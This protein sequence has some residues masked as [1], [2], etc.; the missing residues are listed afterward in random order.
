MTTEAQKLYL[1]RDVRRCGFPASDIVMHCT[2]R[3]IAEAYV[4]THPWCFISEV[5]ANVECEG[6]IYN[7][8]ATA[9][10]LRAEAAAR[11]APKQ[12]R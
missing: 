2:T 4:A 11:N 1:V 12:T 7:P 5:H 6:Y 3:E 8:N 10:I 9:E